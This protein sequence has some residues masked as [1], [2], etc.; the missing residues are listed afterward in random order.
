[1]A[2]TIREQIIQAYLARLNA[3]TTADG[4]NFECAGTIKRAESPNSDALPAVVLWPGEEYPVARYNETES[5][6]VLKFE[7]MAPAGSNENK[8][9]IQEMLIGDLI[10]I[11]TNPNV[12]ITALS[13]DATITKISPASSQAPEETLTAAVAELTVKYTTTTGDPYSQ[14]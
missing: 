13:E 8:S 10:M 5:S 14:Q 11:L 12:V 4:Y 2:N 9:V 3:W 6:M 7:A 1:M